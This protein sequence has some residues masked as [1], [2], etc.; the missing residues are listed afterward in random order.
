VEN[1]GKNNNPAVTVSRMVE[2][3]VGCKWSLSVIKAVRNKLVRPGEI[4]RSIDGISTKVLN[5][6]FNKM[7][8][9]GILDKTIFPE[10][11]PRVEYHLTEF[12]EKFIVI[13]D[14]IDALQGEVKTRK[15]Q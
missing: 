11:P 8:R 15:K 6:R 9:Y 4:Q 1:Q 5:E 7:L 14:N 12:G 10:V 13:I 2:D 3:I